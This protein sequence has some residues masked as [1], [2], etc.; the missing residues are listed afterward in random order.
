MVC[1]HRQIENVRGILIWRYNIT[2]AKCLVGLCLLP[3]CYYF[4]C[5]TM[6]RQMDA[7]ADDFGIAAGNIRS[8]VGNSY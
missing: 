7:N 3:L 5:R 2:P 6:T 8:F 1:A 4:L